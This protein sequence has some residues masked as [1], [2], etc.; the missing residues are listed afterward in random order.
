M[1]A[2]APQGAEDHDGD[3]DPTVDPIVV[4]GAG[5][6]GLLTA[7]ALTQVGAP[8]ALVAPRPTP[9]Q[10]AAD[11]RTFAA[12]G[13]SI[14]LLKRLHVWEELAA[15][16]APL[17]AIR[18]IDGRAGLLRAPEV[19]FEARELGL[20][21]FGAN[22]PQAAM[23]GAA[24]RVVDR[25]PAIR[26]FDTTL[27]AVADGPDRIV[28]TLGDGSL[29]PAALLA[30]ADGRR[31]L[32][33][34]A[35][36]IATHVHDYPQTAIAC[37]FAHARTHD[38]VSTEF[39]GDVGPMTTVPMPD[40]AAGRHHSSLVWVVT[41]AEAE[42]LLALPATAF[43]GELEIRLQGL[44]GR[45]DQLGP[46]AAFPL[47]CI[48]A[49]TLGRGRIALVGEAGHVLPPIG[50]QG[51]NLGLR[52][53]A[54]LAD[55]VQA[56]GRPADRRDG[57]AVVSAYAQAR[58]R[59]VWVRTRA[60][61]LLNRSLLSTALPFDIARGVGLHALAASRTLRRIAMQQGLEPVGARPSL[62]RA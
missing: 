2:M 30:A 7:L 27:A 57:A 20:D 45:L 9:A 15:E 6:A 59:D 1:R 61:D 19:L 17:K 47:T 4:A 52:D 26:W 35:A 46:R 23:V 36:G 41:P 25:T 13:P 28:L 29:L 11:T 49:A 50:A 38:G 54:T 16:A 48:E 53:A 14:D 37:V 22:I 42:R 8:V 34:A 24:M 18:I 40:D 32:A 55:V 33:R 56:A 31:S 3:M 62:M 10:Q 58:S 44:L 12:L 5:P 39:H 51:L 43:L 60:V 21:A